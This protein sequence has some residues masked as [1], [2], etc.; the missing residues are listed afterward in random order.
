MQVKATVSLCRRYERVPYFRYLILEVLTISNTRRIDC[1]RSQTHSIDTL[2]ARSLL[3]VLDGNFRAPQLAKKWS[4]RGSFHL[5]PQLL[6][7]S[8]FAG[9]LSGIRPLVSKSSTETRN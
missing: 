9:V 7:G 1:E 4:D 5:C 6:T 8:R 2:S 3:V